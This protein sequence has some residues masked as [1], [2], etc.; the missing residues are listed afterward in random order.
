MGTCFSPRRNTDAEAPG[1]Q[2]RPPCGPHAVRTRPA[3]RQGSIVVCAIA[4]EPGATAR[5][6]P[7]P[8]AAGGRRHERRARRRCRSARH[9]PGAAARPAHRRDTSALAPLPVRVAANGDGTWEVLDGFKR[10]AQLDARRSH[11]RAGRRRGRRRRRAQSAAAGGQRP[12]PHGERHGRGARG[13][14]AGRRRRAHADADRQAARPRARL[15]RPSPHA[16]PPARAQ[17]ARATSMP[18]GCPPPPAYRLAVFPRAEQPRLAERPPAPRAAHARGGR[19]PRG[20]ARHRRRGHARGAAARSAQRRARAPGFGRLAPRPDGPR[21]PGPL[22]SDGA[23]A[24]GVAA[25]RPHRLRRPRPSG[26]GGL[27]AAPG[28][29]GRPARPHGPGGDCAC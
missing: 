19:V 12:A 22:R 3:P 15:G 29:P 4:S 11:A 27:S 10:L 17:R 13:A 16:R 14:L 28:R 1:P 18:A 8:S 21:A 9:G 26:P 23:R 5:R 7:T 6:S 24:R 2:V 25:P 20:L